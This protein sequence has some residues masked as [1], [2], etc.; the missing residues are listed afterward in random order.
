MVQFLKDYLKYRRTVMYWLCVVALKTVWYIREYILPGSE[1]WNVK[2][3]VL[4]DCILP[5][6]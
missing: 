1:P 3:V 4:M 5:G 2:L 6:M